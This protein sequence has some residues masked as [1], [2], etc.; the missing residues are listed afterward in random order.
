[1]KTKHHPILSAAGA[2]ACDQA[3]ESTRPIRRVRPAVGLSALLLVI[4]FLSSPVKGQCPQGWNVGGHWGLKQSNQE[5]PNNMRLRMDGGGTITGTAW[6]QA[7]AGAKLERGPVT[8]RVSGNDVEF[9][10]SWSNGLVGVYNGKIDPQGKITGTGYEKNSPSKK[11]SWFSDKA[12]SC[13][14][15]A[16]QPSTGRRPRS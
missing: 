8:G 7:G 4:L 10:V 11:V 13:G 6:Y 3:I 5:V 2:K 12:M 9:V 15:T 16:E 14:P 1:M